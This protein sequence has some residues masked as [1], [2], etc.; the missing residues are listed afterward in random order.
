MF[1]VVLSSCAELYVALYARHRNR[2]MDMWCTSILEYLY[3]WKSTQPSTTCLRSHS[4]YTVDTSAI[5]LHRPTH[6]FGC[7]SVAGRHQLRHHRRHSRHRAP[8]A[9]VEDDGICWLLRCVARLKFYTSP[10]CVRFVCLFTFSNTC[11]WGTISMCFCSPN[12]GWAGVQ[13]VFSSDILY[14]P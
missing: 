5:Y 2:S 12:G 3:Y 10:R 1:R 13:R 11:T 4:V 7:G 9:D 14:V 6:A 8:N